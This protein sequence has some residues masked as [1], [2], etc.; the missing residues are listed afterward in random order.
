MR[1]FLLFLRRKIKIKMCITTFID[2]GHDQ[3]RQYI[4]FPLEESL[5]INKNRFILTFG[6]DYF[7]ED[8]HI[9]KAS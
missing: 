1:N 5:H 4:A 7:I 8:Y 2:R 9:M 6:N 3:F